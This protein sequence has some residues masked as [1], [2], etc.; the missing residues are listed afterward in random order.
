MGDD[1]HCIEVKNFDPPTGEMV[2]DI[3]RLYDIVS[4]GD[5]IS[6][7]SVTG[8]LALLS[9]DQSKTAKSVAEARNFY[10]EKVHSLSALSPQWSDGIKSIVDESLPGSVY[11]CVV[12]IGK[13]IIPECR[14]NGG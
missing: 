11:A 5:G 1:L 6:R 4:R 12:R 13:N 7:L 8:W 9:S 3:K 10:R 2:S 14:P